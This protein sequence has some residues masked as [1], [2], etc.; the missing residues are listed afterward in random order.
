[1]QDKQEVRVRPTHKGNCP[2]A[3]SGEA[4]EAPRKCESSVVNSRRN[5]PEYI[6]WDI[7]P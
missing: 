6:P 3:H 7:D 5:G 2:M 4:L 1:M